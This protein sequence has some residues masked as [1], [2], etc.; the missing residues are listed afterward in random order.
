LRENLSGDRIDREI[1]A[2]RFT[3]QCGGDRMHTGSDAHRRLDLFAENPASRK[4]FSWLSI[5]TPQPLIADTARHQSSK[6][7]LSTPGLPITF[8]RSR[9]GKVL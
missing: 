6:S 1:R 9:A 8:I 2:V 4:I 5:H 3:I 7:A